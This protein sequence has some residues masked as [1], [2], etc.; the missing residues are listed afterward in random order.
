MIKKIQSGLLVALGFM[1]LSHAAAIEGGHPNVV[2]IYADDLGYGEIQALN[3]K[4]GK[5]LT[6]HLDQLVK[7]GITFT[8]AHT[9]SSVCTPSR[10]GLLTG[11]YNWRTTLQRGVLKGGKPC[12]IAPDR[13]TL[14][15]LFQSQGYN[16]AMFGKWH[17][18]YKYDMST[19]KE[20][21]RTNKGKGYYLSKKPIGARIIDGPVTRGFDYFFGF[22]ESGSMSSI[23]VNDKISEEIPVIDVL[24]RLTDEVTKYIDKNAE[25]AKKGKPFFLY[26]PMSSPHSPV[27]P[28]KE[29]QGK[30]GI[31]PHG[32]FVMQTDASV[33]SVMTALKRNGLTENTIVIF[34]ADNGTSGPAAKTTVLRELGHFSSGELRGEKS[35]IWEGGH[36]VPF[37]LRWPGI[38]KPNSSYDNMISLADLMATFADLFSVKL[39]EKTAEDSISFLPAVYGKD[40]S[41]PRETVISHS[42]HGRFTIRQ[43]D[44]K[45]LLS[46]GSGGSTPIRDAEATAQG[47]PEMQLY[48]LKNDISEQQNLVAQHPEKAEALIKLLETIV[49]NGRSTPGALQLNDGKIDIWKKNLNQK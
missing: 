48:N 42:V 7:D 38:S 44:W 14:G 39:N 37:L 47:L 9:T 21:K 49:A 26:F 34:S 25:T 32:D 29:W 46:P 10:Y 45:L 24:P 13:M 43:G 36:R 8:D 11:R 31:G 19:V 12:L 35:D 2:I 27:V 15:K 22:H 41:N 17:L 30:S 18:N 23:V 33:G 40:V 20:V 4:R 3:P 6:P 5:I 28:S 16:T 1:S